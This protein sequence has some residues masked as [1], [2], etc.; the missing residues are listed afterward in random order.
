[1]EAKIIEA[2]ESADSSLETAVDE[3]IAEHDGD[4]RAAIRALLVARDYLEA[5]RDRALGQVSFGYTRGR[6]HQD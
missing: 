2:C 4:A 6:F 5:A 3:A 1:M